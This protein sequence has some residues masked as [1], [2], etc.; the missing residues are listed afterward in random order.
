MTQQIDLTLRNISDNDDFEDDEV[1]IRTYINRLEARIEELEASKNCDGCKWF[2]LKDR[3]CKQLEESSYPDYYVSDDSGFYIY[4]YMIASKNFY[5][6][7]HEP[8]DSK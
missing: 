1:I 4:N 6:S 8:K 7:M 2:N 3:T 5:C